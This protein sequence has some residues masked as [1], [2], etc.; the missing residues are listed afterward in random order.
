MAEQDKEKFQQVY[1]APM[2]VNK[3]RSKVWG[4]MVKG[5]VIIIF[6]HVKLTEF[7]KYAICK[8]F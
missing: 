6:H 3:K 7:E 8:I 5:E 1:L 4:D 2:Q